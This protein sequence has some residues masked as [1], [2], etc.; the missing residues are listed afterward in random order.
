MQF[1]PV[2]GKAWLLTGNVRYRAISRNLLSDWISENQLDR[3][4]LDDRDGGGASRNEHLPSLELLWPF[5][6][7]EY[8]WLEGD[9]FVVGTS[10]V[11]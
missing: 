10:S 3:C 11:H 7:A 4:Q 2:L 9:K 5:P 6:A 8:E 1:L